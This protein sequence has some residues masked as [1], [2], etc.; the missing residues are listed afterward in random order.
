MVIRSAG[1]ELQ[2]N[3]FGL[4][5]ASAWRSRQR[6]TLKTRCYDRP[7]DHEIFWNESWSEQVFA[8]GQYSRPYT[9]RL[10]GGATF[11]VANE[12]RF[13]F[14]TRRLLL[15]NGTWFD[16][17]GESHALSSR[18]VS[19]VRRLRRSEAICW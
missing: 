17:K 5:H 10:P 13:G 1:G 8:G 16:P 18:S 3:V 9:L 4:V 6:F 12:I 14:T 2:G 7:A 19:A 15:E 11:A